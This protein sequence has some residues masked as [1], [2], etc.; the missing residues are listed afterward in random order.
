MQ[1]SVGSLKNATIAMNIIKFTHDLR[2]DPVYNRILNHEGGNLHSLI[3]SALH[4]YAPT[5]AISNPKEDSNV[6]TM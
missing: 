1:T 6:F 4:Q 3:E 5:T 2:H